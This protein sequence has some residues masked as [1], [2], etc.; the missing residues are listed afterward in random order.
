[1][2]D[3][4][5]FNA[6]VQGLAAAVQAQSVGFEASVDRLQR[7]VVTAAERSAETIRGAHDRLSAVVAQ[8][9]GER[10]VNDSAFETLAARLAELNRSV[11]RLALLRPRSAG[12][13]LTSIASR[14][15][16]TPSPRQD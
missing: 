3:A 4:E 16:G 15:W 11:G 6:S 5:A 14:L 12:G 8:R 2:R 9:A 1:L 10:V 13:L 7:E